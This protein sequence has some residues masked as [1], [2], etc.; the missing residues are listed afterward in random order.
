MEGD[1]GKGGK[2]LAPIRGAE[3]WVKVRKSSC[4]HAVLLMGHH[5]AFCPRCLTLSAADYW[6]AATAVMAASPCRCRSCRVPHAA[7]YC[8]S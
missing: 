1:K 5:A 8:R 7:F 2:L 6:T 3:A 4:L